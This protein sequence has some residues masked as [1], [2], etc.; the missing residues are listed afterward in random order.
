MDYRNIRQVIDTPNPWTERQ[1]QVDQILVL[2]DS[3][4]QQLTATSRLP[5]ILVEPYTYLT[6]NPGKEIRTK[7][8]DAF[9][10]W[11]QVPEEDLDVIRRVVR[12]LHGGS[13][14]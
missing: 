3:D 1:E 8:I 9:N 12:M 4:R 11:L 14:L 13:L 5:Q 2:Y 6:Q 10:L 7:L